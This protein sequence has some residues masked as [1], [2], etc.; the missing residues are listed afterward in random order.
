MKLYLVQHGASL[1]KDV[2]PECSLSQEGMD[3]VTEMADYLKSCGVNVF[4][5]FHSTKKRAKQTAEILSST[6]SDNRCEEIDGLKP[7]DD[8]EP[9]IKI[10]PEFKQD[11][12]LIG[13]LPFMSK[14]VSELLKHEK[15]ISTLQFLPGS[16]ACLEQN[17]EG[18]WEIIFFIRPDSF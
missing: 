17:D 15:D 18:K 2:D 3:T 4:S 1:S 16:V 14:F 10:I 11:T 7:M 6:L 5:I 13:H 8:V 12:M 9:I